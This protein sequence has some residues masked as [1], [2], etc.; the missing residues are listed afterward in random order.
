MSLYLVHEPI[1]KWITFAI[2]GALTWPTDLENIPEFAAKRTL[3]I[4]AVPIHIIVS[5]IAATALTLLL[6]EPAKNLLRSKPNK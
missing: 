4:W 3:P 1:L 6:E 5:I 2:H